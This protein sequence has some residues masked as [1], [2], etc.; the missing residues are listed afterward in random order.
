L[1]RVT[2]DST[3]GGLDEGLKRTRGLPR[4]GN[5]LRKAR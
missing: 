3:G 1:K 5:R 4:E 2:K